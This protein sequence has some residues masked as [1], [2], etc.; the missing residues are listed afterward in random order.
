MCGVTLAQVCLKPKLLETVAR[1][2]ITLATLCNFTF[3]LTVSGARSRNYVFTFNNPP[4]HWTL[5][6]H[7]LYPE[8]VVFCAG[9]FEIAPG[10]GTRHFQG[11]VC[12]QHAVGIATAGRLLGCAG[13]HFERRRGS[14]SEAL[15]YVTKHD[16]RDPQDV[17]IVAGKPPPEGQGA[18]TDL[19][20]LRE[21]LLA[22]ASMVDL[23][24]SHF[25]CFAK[26]PRG[27]QLLYSLL[28][29]E[30]RDSP[31]ECYY[32]WGPTGTGKSRAAYDFATE[33]SQA[34]YSAPIG[35]SSAVW[36]DGYDARRHGVVLLDDFYHNYKI[37][38]LLKLLDRYPLSAPVKGA[39]VN[40]SSSTVFIT[41]NIGL[42]EQYSNC[43]PEAQRALWRRFKHVVRCDESVWTLCSYDNPT[44]PNYLSPDV[45]S[46]RL[47]Q[48][49]APF[50]KRQKT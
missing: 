44:G 28:A 13:A 26:Y 17:P 48:L 22:G 50:N 7:L 5:D 8:R 34:L 25:E 15:L 21:D 42:H 35:E 14:H 23:A 12:F 38:F 46:A 10:T 18:R 33:H 37:H 27:I 49:V 40:F 47:G 6:G 29:S 31:P 4:V 16:S 1:S 2:S 43:P 39:H 3:L 20:D 19:A 32:L 45:G 41:S 11:Y 24:R 36:F 9:Q 30:P